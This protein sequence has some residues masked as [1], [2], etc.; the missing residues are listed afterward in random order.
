MKD[1]QIRFPSIV[2]LKRKDFTAFRALSVKEG[3]SAKLLDTVEETFAAATPF[4]K[5]LC[6]ALGVQY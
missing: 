2:D 4:M 3:S 1:A 5:F 6:K